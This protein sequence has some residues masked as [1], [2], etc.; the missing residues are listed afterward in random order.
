VTVTRTSATARR[1]PAPSRTAPAA[2]PRLTVVPAPRRRAAR[3]P[4]VLLV[5]ALLGVG[6]VALLV[7]NTKLAENSMRLQ[8]LQSEATR[9]ADQEQGLSQ[10]VARLSSPQ[11]LAR[12]A[13]ELGLVD[14]PNPAFLDTTNGKVLGQAGPGTKG[15]RKTR[16]APGGATGAGPAAG[17][18]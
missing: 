16:Q 18:R 14:K 12:R 13:E 6:L 8:D 17:N 4:F 7:L 2:A 1:A 5:V 3:A 10:E 11:E 15:E 9:L